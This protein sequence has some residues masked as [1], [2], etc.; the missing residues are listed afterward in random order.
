MKVMRIMTGVFSI[1]FTSLMFIYNVV[2]IFMSGGYGYGFVGSQLVMMIVA[3]I[4]LLILYVTLICCAFLSKKKRALAFPTLMLAIYLSLDSLASMVM[5]LFNP[6]GIFTIVFT[7]SIFIVGA[8]PTLIFAIIYCAKA[9]PFSSG[10]DSS[11]EQNTRFEVHRQGNK[12]AYD[13]ILKAK[14]LLDAGA[15]TIEEFKEIKAKLLF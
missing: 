5:A 12:N 4:I 1:I 2:N 13:D 10:D 11:A 14:Q 8:L 3:T 6:F 9:K 15:I 7:V